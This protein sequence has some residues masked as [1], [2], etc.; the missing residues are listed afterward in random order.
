MK[1]TKEQVARM[2]A[3][4]FGRFGIKPKASEE[5][6]KYAPELNANGQEGAGDGEI[7][8]YG[9]V[10][11]DANYEMYKWMFGDAVICPSIF[12]KSLEAIDGTA[13]IRINSPGG[14]FYACAAIVNLIDERGEVN[15]RVDGLA[16]SAASAIM[17]ACNE[18]EIGAMGTV[19]IHAVH[20]YVEG[21]AQDMEKAA[22]VMKK[23]TMQ[24]AT[25]YARRMD[26]KAEAIAETLLEDQYYTADEAKEAGLVDKVRKPK[27]NKG[28]KGGKGDVDPQ[29]FHQ[30]QLKSEEAIA[31]T[32]MV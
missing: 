2:Q 28:G 5:W 22:K 12:K 17:A 7:L 20:A 27:N 14:S 31:A 9:V 3:V 18:V 25:I 8:M 23:M 29:A 15:A 19:M 1:L 26:A 16:A 30:S 4:L 10:C 11:D 24:A 6:Q 21:N 32:L 13:T